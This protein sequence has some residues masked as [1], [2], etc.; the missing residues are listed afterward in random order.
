MSTA[1]RA[2]AFSGVTV[3]VG[4]LTL[5]LLPVP[6]LRSLGYGGLLIPLVTVI[7][8]LTLLPGVTFRVGPPT[9]PQESARATATPT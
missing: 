8:A 9:R 7:S 1:G 5:V 2:V 6:F 3:G 4:L